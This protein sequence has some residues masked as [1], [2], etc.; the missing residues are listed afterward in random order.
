MDILTEEIKG[1]LLLLT[2]KPNSWTIKKNMKIFWSVQISCLKVYWTNVSK[3]YLYSTKPKHLETCLWWHTWMCWKF[4]KRRWVQLPY[5]RS[6]SSCKHKK[7]PAQAKKGLLYD[8]QEL[9]LFFKEKYPTEKN[10][11]FRVLAS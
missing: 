4:L 9:Y 3:R 7:K 2:L 1:K 11:L 6:K 5:A 8:L 10:L